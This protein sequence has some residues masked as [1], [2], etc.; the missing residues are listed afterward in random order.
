M[1]S[2]IAYNLPNLSS[3]LRSVQFLPF[4]LL[5]NGNV[6]KRAK[7][8]SA[9]TWDAAAPLVTWRSRDAVPI[10]R[11]ETSDLRD[12][13]SVTYQIGVFERYPWL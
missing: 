1:P 11:C 7:L 10:P 3:L 4:F 13:N 2:V 12:T 5:H 8:F 9:G 6:S